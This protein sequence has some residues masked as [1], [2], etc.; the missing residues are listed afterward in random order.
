M[1]TSC[2]FLQ[3]A[4]PPEFKSAIPS[5]LL[6]NSSER[7]K[8]IIE[9]LSVIGQKSDWL[10]GETQMQSHD[11]QIIKKETQATNGKVAATIR[12]LAEIE[13]REG[14][15]S[16]DWAEIKQIVSFK[17]FIG[18]YLLNRYAL[19]AFVVLGVGFIRVMSDDQL[20][21]FFFKIVGF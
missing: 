4:L 21:E 8:F 19:G 6:E 9:Q 1:S 7:D 11:I 10:I 2:N 17:Q 14:D 20:R 18:K 3:M 12:N 5:H 13:K 16:A 15:K